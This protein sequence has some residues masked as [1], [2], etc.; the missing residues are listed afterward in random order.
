MSND[1]IL[2]LPSSEE[3]S[4]PKNT[5]PSADPALNVIRNKIDHLYEK[6]PSAKEEA[7]EISKVGVHSKHQAFMDQLQQSGASLSQIQ[8]TWHKYYESLPDKEKHQVWREFYQNQSKTANVKLSHKKVV[9]NNKHNQRSPHLAHNLTQTPPRH[10]ASEMTGDSLKQKIVNTASARG[11]LKPKHHFQSLLFG[12]SM[13][14][15]VLVIFM[16]G[17]FNERFIAPFISPSKTASS[18][19]IILDPNSSSAVGAEPKLVIPKLNVEVPVV[20][21]VKTNNEADIQRGL[22]DGV[23]HYPTTPVPG[24]K[25]NVAVVGHSSN[26]IFNPGK[27]KYVFTLLNKLQEGDTFFMNY[28][29]QRYVYKI[30][31]RQIVKPSDVWVLGPQTDKESTATLITCDPPGT[32]VN[33]LVLV[34]EQISPEPLKNVAGASSTSTLQQPSTVPGNS[35]SLFDRIFGR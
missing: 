27:Y 1:N 28:N 20:Y 32:N 35:K 8:T 2:P 34:G 30:Y 12:M 29:G 7:K 24:Q 13:G 21:T 25:G 3:T 33:R 23:V 18:S 22:E 31:K 6:E 5:G 14:L 4:L 10:T 11:K 19:P 17:F 26:N 9:Q 16:F 15:I